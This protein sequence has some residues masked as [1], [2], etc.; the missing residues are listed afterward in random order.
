[1]SL[2][3]LTLGSLID[4]AMENVSADIDRRTGSIIY[5]TIA[6]ATV[7]ILFLAMEG[8]NI[9][10]I[11]F[12]DTTYGEYLDRL[13]AGRAMA[14]YPATNAIK[15]AQ[16]ETQEGH[17]IGLPIGSRFSAVD[18]ELIYAIIEEL[19]AG[20]YLVE[21][22]TAGTVGN[23]YYGDLV[24][25][26]QVVS[27]ASATITG[28]H[29]D[30]RDT[31]TDDELKARYLDEFKR[32]SFGGNVSQYDEEL[33]KLEGV[34]DVQVHRAYP[35]SGHVLISVVGPTYRKI[36]TS[37]IGELQ[38]AIDPTINGATGTGLGI[39]PIFH[40][41]TITTPV[42][43]TINVSFK[44]QVLSGYT[45]EQLR[46]PITEK[47]EELFAQLR[48]EWGVL[49][50]TSHTY[51]TILYVSRVIVAVSGILGVAN[52]SEVKFDG[53][54]ADLSLSET[55]ARQELPI[56]GQVTING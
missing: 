27:L 40:K 24:P 47:L 21:C 37:L 20:E 44:L 54:A 28:D 1:M 4:M 26:S 13:V 15:K 14:R 7:P 46:A 42:E 43:R 41:V 32:N 36:S 53:V 5:D 10:D 31:E 6:S 48:K 25:I 11:T 56:L 12:I 34:G 52:I 51:Q 18:S 19:G 22:E 39:A 17:A 16:F 50:E 3:D 33:K 30:A 35:S 29:T 8:A 45:V 23:L 2:K 49:D 9:E 55:G 38:E